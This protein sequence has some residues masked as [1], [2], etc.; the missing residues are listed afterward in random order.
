[1]NGQERASN[2]RTFKHLQR[3][4]SADHAGYTAV[5]GRRT[6]QRP[7]WRVTLGLDSV[8]KWISQAAKHAGSPLVGLSLNEARRCSHRQEGMEKVKTTKS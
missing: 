5:F 4:C 3:W 8:H 7:A 6:C 1:M 2:L